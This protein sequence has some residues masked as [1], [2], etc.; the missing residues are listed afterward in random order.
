MGGGGVTLGE[1]LNLIVSGIAT[2]YTIFTPQ[3]SYVLHIT[4]CYTVFHMVLTCTHYTILIYH[5]VQCS[6]L[7]NMFYVR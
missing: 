7:Y 5:K 2:H 6:T 3:G 4:Q 1:I